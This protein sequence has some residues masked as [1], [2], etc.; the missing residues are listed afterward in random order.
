MATTITGR[1]YEVTEKIRDLI[2]RKLDKIIEKLFDRVIE[3]RVVLQVEKYRN[4]CEV[5]VTGKEHVVK[6]VQESDESM[7]D[8]INRA[9]DHVKRQAQK[10]RSTIRD[11]HRKDGGLNKTVAGLVTEWAVQV[12]E[13]GRLRKPGPK[14]LPRIIKTNS[15]TILPM[16]IEDAAESLDGSKN[17]FI[18]FRDLDNDRISVIYKRRDNNLGL[19]APEV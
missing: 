18:V 14:G 6:A 7:Q 3:V 5:H 2:T 11:H 15:L 13:P 19:I 4:I 1:H 16:T 8:A 17:E 9:L 12:L 10:N